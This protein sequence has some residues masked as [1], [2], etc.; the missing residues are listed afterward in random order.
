[1]HPTQL[2]R[3]CYGLALH[4][5][6]TNGLQSYI[7]TDPTSL[8]RPIIM[9]INCPPGAS[10][11]ITILILFILNMFSSVRRSRFFDIPLVSLAKESSQRFIA[12]LY[13][14]SLTNNDVT[15]IVF[16]PVSTTS[17]NCLQ[18]FSILIL[19]H[20]IKTGFHSFNQYIPPPPLLA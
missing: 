12:I 7:L 10:Q 6:N 13:L 8:N 2:N 4:S 5:T 17:T 1:M 3:E 9:P 19:S 15:F 14:R 18:S 11:E 16:R 20:V